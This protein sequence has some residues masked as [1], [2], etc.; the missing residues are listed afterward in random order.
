MQR[1]VIAEEAAHEAQEI[2]VAA[3]AYL[4]EVARRSHRPA[5]QIEPIVWATLTALFD[6][7]DGRDA[8]L[9]WERLSTEGRQTALRRF[10]SD[11][12]ASGG[13]ERDTRAVVTALR[14][15][16]VH[17]T[18]PAD[19]P[20]LS[21]DF[22]AAI[23]SVGLL[24]IEGR[25]SLTR[26]ASPEAEA[27]PLREL[28]RENLL[29]VF[30]GWQELLGRAIGGPELA[31]RLGVSRQRLNALRREGRLLGLKVPIRRELQYPTWQFDPEGR[32][33]AALPR[34]LTAARE[35]GIE[36]ADLD[37][38]MVSPTAGEG[39]PLVDHLRAGDEALVLG[40]IRAA[41]E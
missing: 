37:A 7:V 2:A 20:S 32:P 28:E 14:N 27:A 1:L 18:L 26:S 13:R 29:R 25:A 21:I 38:L 16:L 19:I 15:F 23:A 31:R 6:W 5:K 40:V 11:V 8:W 10:L 4:R 33:L 34:L 22:V 12:I 36:P 35:A 41:G 17:N 30:E 24:L 9:N 3:E 39:R